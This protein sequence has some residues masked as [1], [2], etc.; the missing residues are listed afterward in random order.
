MSEGHKAAPLLAGASAG[1]GSGASGSGTPASDAPSGNHVNVLRAHSQTHAEL[2]RRAKI[3]QRETL[4][5]AVQHEF[6]LD[7][8]SMTSGATAGMRRNSS[9]P[10]LSRLDDGLPKIII[11]ICGGCCVAGRVSC[12]VPCRLGA[13]ASCPRC[14]NRQR[15]LPLTPSLLPSSLP[16]CLLD[17]P[18]FSSL[19][20]Y[21]P[22]SDSPPFLLAR[23]H[24]QEGS[25]EA[26]ESHCGAA[27]A[28]WRV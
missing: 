4:T 9:A 15:S 23:S 5:P 24:G 12:G 28:V 13:P 21:T 27:A 14:W 25:V 2:S 8:P 7:R 26:D 1:D 20:T 11:G 3:V 10:L 19:L 6:G 17:F 18:F 16:V 22:I